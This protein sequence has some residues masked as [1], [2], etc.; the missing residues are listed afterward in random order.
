MFVSEEGLLVVLEKKRLPSLA[1]HAMRTS[2]NLKD[3]LQLPQTSCPQI[4]ILSA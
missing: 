4:L 1:H 3:C 2:H